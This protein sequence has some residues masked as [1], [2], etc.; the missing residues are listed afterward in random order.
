MKI[1][2]KSTLTNILSLR[3]RG[4]MSPMWRS[5][6][7]SDSFDNEIISIMFEM[8]NENDQ[9]K[10]L[11]KQLEKKKAEGIGEFCNS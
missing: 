7:E 4:S 8:K 9:T 3:S 1:F 2:L 6:K 10:I 5:F 11:T